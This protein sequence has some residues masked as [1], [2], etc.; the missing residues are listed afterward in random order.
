ME[1]EYEEEDDDKKAS[2]SMFR[3]R[4]ATTAETWAEKFAVADPARRSHWEPR[5][6]AITDTNFLTHLRTATGLPPLPPAPLLRQIERATSSA[7][8]FASPSSALVPLPP[9]QRRFEI[10]SKVRAMLADIRSIIA[11][12]EE[13]D[14]EGDGDLL[15]DMD[16]GEDDD[17]EDESRA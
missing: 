13:M 15:G 1:A 5:L 17:E 12:V 2:S 10:S 11:G 9:S 14:D 3:F 4:K 8:S 16:D 7:A 6:Q